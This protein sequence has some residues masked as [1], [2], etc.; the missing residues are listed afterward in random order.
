[1]YTLRKQ[2]PRDKQAVIS[3]VITTIG[4]HLGERN[5][6]L[7]CFLI[8]VLSLVSESV[9]AQQVSRAANPFKTPKSMSG[10]VDFWV[11]IFAKH[12]R[13]NVVIHH[14]DWP[15]A[16]FQVLDFN[17]DAKRMSEVALAKHRKRTVEA[18][19]K[20]VH[21][22][23]K[24][25]ATGSSPA[26]SLQERISRELSFLPGGRAKYQKIIDDN[27][28]RTQTGIREKFEQ[29][30][31]R[32]GRYLRTIEQIFTDEYNLPVE[33]TRLPFVESSFDYQAYSSVGA[34][35]IWQFMPGTGRIYMRVDNIVDERRDVIASTRGAAQYLR[36][37]KQ[38]LGTWPLALTSY[39]HG[40][41]GVKRRTREIGSHDIATI[42]EHP[43]KR[44]FGFAS[45]N[46]YA[47]FLAAL[48]VYENYP[49]YFPNIAPESPLHIVEHKLP[50]SFSLSYLSKA[51]GASS[52]ELLAY[53][54]GLSKNVQRGRYRVPRGY[55]LKVHPKYSINLAQLNKPQPG[56]SASSAVYGGATY[57]VRRGDTLSGIARRYNTTVSQ[58]KKLND[59]RSDRVYIGQTLVVRERENREAYLPRESTVAEAGLYRVKSGDTLYSIGRRHGLSTRELIQINNLKSSTIRVGQQLRLNTTTSYSNSGQYTVKAGDTLYSIGRRYG[60]STSEL[61]RINNLKSSAIRIGQK[62]RFNNISSNKTRQHT[63]KTGDTL[64]GISRKY[65][66]SM[67]SISQINNL[68]SSRLRAG[69]RLRIP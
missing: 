14:R 57:R 46:F 35:G 36:H 45:N 33:L 47:E 5:A 31:I 8:L 42:V 50:H 15:Q 65:G 9:V 60:L 63:V 7:R 40:I 62:L 22:A 6:C 27:L 19:V 39:N 10:R 51:L 54:Y 59:L 29:A 41:A 4:K 69:Q 3:D 11:D 67:R 18:A 66:V 32:S 61:M 25:L 26:T 16:V 43:T 13:H 52:S 2:Q 64:W 17:A 12:G 58:V 56:I 68:K 37:A 20:Q 34:A 48:E 53:N 28:I 1:M 55:H 23:V 49:R 38:E 21:Q 30:I 44:V 24:H